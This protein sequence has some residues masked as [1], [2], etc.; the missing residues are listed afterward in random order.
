MRDWKDQNEVRRR[1][2]QNQY[3]KVNMDDVDRM[4]MHG[5][6]EEKNSRYQNDRAKARTTQ[7]DVS[8]PTHQSLS[9]PVLIITIPFFF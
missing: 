2:G 1:L 9:C 7:L 3:D 6:Y 5:S 8:S 4:D